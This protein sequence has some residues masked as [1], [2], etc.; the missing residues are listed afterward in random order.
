MVEIDT[1]IPIYDKHTIEVDSRAEN[2]VKMVQNRL[3]MYTVKFRIAM[4]YTD[5]MVQI[6]IIIVHA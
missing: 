6:Y 3:V 2:F 4:M 5:C 1:N